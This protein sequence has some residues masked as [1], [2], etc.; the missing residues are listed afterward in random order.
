MTN[1]MIVDDEIITANIIRSQFDWNAMGVGNV[2]IANSYQQACAI[3][4]HYDVHIMVCDIEMPQKSGLDLLEWMRSR[5]M[6]TVS[7]FLTGY[8]DFSYC[9][10]ALELGGLEYVLKPAKFN[11]LEK[12]ILH[13]VQKV[14]S[15][16]EENLY[17]E[18]GESWLN[19]ATAIRSQFWT[20]VT[21][22]SIQPTERAVLLAAKNFGIALEKEEKYSV[23]LVRSR[24]DFT[25]E[26]NWDKGSFQFALSKILSELT[27]TSIITTAALPDQ[28][29]SAFI[30]HKSNDVDEKFLQNSC[31]NLMA[32][33]S[34]YLFT[35]VDV[36]MG[37][38]SFAWELSAQM[39]ELLRMR[40][41]TVSVSGRVLVLGRSCI[42]MRFSPIPKER[43]ESLLNFGQFSFL[44]NEINSYL[45]RQFE[46]DL[47][48]VSVKAL[49]Y[50]VQEYIRI[51]QTYLDNKTVPS[52]WLTEETP[53][54]YY[55]ASCSISS[56]KEYIKWVVDKL[57]IYLR[58]VGMQG[59]F[60][61][62]AKQFIKQHVNEDISRDSIAQE[63]GINAEY[64]SRLFKKREGKSLI[65]YIQKRKIEEAAGLL[66]TNQSISEVAI[67]IGYH[68]FAY[69]TQIFKK[70][71]GLTPSA[72]K[73]QLNQ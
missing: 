53:N 1:L 3:C 52:Y 46:K 21:N 49:S 18:Y 34:R 16:R 70:H 40:Q 32:C 42:K 35:E 25:R 19:N 9:K 69:F 39:A 7:I 58:E 23:V 60:V 62:K 45:E 50:F 71:T 29:L 41:E 44:Q 28:S 38:Y 24:I 63:L 68:N 11:V 57:P 10:R 14:Q 37:S 12:A 17:I 43:W 55:L 31:E 26:N 65:E 2:Y 30:V 66:Q 54:L 4:D 72:F 13:A 33:C 51:V 61:K 36:V 20:E 6:D 27:E 73:K 47:D 59:D 8:D 5:G 15:R 48:G 22:E 56:C 67:Q 64:L